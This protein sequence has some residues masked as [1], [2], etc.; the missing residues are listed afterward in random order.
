MM[1]QTMIAPETLEDALAAMHAEPGSMA[2]AG[3]ATLVAMMNAGLVEPDSLVALRHVDTLRA[4]RQLDD[5]GIE[6]GAMRRHRETALETPFKDGQTVLSHAASQIANPTVRNMGTLGGSIAFN[7]PGADYPAALVA[8]N[9]TILIAGATGTREVAA[10]A[11]F[12]DWY[13]TALEAGELV[14]GVRV[15]AAPVGSIGHYEKLARIAGDFAMASVALQ[16]TWSGDSIAAA[17]IAIGGCG[18]TPLHLAEADDMLIGLGADSDALGKAG[19][20][21]AQA[22]D[23]VD[24]VRAS[25]DYRR[26]VIPRLLAKA[27]REI[28]PAREAA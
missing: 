7:D 22:A 24:D 5:G 28:A 21:L 26:K 12:V 1:T 6:L 18:P 17:R 8:A 3:G 9:A 10:E 13:T 16:V 20:L 25:A 4:T 2:L 14:A 15:P 19:L 23:P 11:F 27:M